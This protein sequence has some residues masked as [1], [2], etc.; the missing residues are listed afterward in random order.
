MIS[1]EMFY[2]QLTGYSLPCDAGYICLEGS[3]VAKPTN[4]IIGYV[5][6]E[7][8]YCPSGAVK[9]IQCLK[10]T[11]GPATALGKKYTMFIYLFV[12]N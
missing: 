9:E 10:G 1:V 7:G 4:N 2:K 3:D 11:Y 6:P 5:C 12:T 8:H